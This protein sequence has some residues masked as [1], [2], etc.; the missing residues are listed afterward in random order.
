MAAELRFDA[1]RHEY[2][3]D[4]VLVPSITQMLKA[5]GWVDPAFYT[6]AARARG[7]KVHTLAMAHDLGS[8]DL[9]HVVQHRGYVLA[10][11]EAMRAIRPTW[12]AIEEPAVHSGYPFAGTPDRVGTLFGAQGI[13]DIKTG[14]PEP[15][16]AVQL[17]LQAILISA[18]GGLPPTSYLRANLYLKASGR[19]TLVRHPH[20]R[21]F[22]HAYRVL[23][24]CC[25]KGG[26]R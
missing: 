24:A 8:L 26:R 20:R 18:N 10:Y 9:H 12:D 4:G 22:D 7:Q 15:A 2:W 3:L 21:D 19:Y 14:A 6:E 16:D 1:E 5:T 13:A 11:L 23:D 17:A 25:S